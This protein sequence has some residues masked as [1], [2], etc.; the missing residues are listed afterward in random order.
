L[1]NDDV[2]AFIDV[3]SLIIAINNIANP[4]V[5]SQ[6]TC[7]IVHH[8]PKPAFIQYII[9]IDLFTSTHAALTARR[10]IRT[11]RCTPSLSFRISR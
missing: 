5:T 6:G 9:T 8:P 10:F 3:G 4:S 7:Y 1:E 2:L 11:G